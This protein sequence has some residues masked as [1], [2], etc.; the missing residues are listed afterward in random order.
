[1]RYAFLDEE[2]KKEIRRSILK[3]IAIPG[4]IVGFASRELPVA[5]GWGTGGLQVTLAIINEEDTLKVIDQ[6]CDGSVNAVNI[7]NFIKSVTKV[8][9]TTKTL[10]ASII[11]TRHRVPEIDLQE[12]QTLVYQVP[13]PDILE[14]VEPNISKAK[15]LHANADYS[16]L[17]VLLYEDTSMYGDSRI[18]NRY[19]VMVND[20]Y[21]MDPSP[22]PKYDTP[23]LN[24]C[25]AL[26]LFGAGREKKIY[27]IPPY[28]KVEPLKFEDR[29]FKVENFDGKACARCGS[30]HSFLDEVYDDEG[31]AT[32]YCNDTDYCDTQKEKQGNN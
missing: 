29:E 16:K 20:R 32:Y 21:A 22:I 25:K 12:G 13:M 2:A 17:W 3:A 8:N 28:T 15:L 4:Y 10:D 24:D 19:P 6:G 31:K 9:T 11:Q 5:R 1:M 18:S 27:A 30:V 23:K 7:R 14:T 26:Q